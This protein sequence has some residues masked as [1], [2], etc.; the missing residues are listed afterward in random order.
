MNEEKVKT[1]KTEVTLRQQIAERQKEVDDLNC[2][3]QQQSED[4]EAKINELLTRLQEQT[5]LAVKLQ[6]EIDE[7]EW[8]EEG[9]EKNVELTQNCKEK[10]Q[11][12]TQQRSLTANNKEISTRS[13]SSIQMNQG[14]HLAGSLASISTY[15]T[16]SGTN[17]AMESFR[18]PD[19]QSYASDTAKSDSNNTMEDSLNKSCTDERLKLPL[20]SNLMTSDEANTAGDFSEMS[21]IK[22]LTVSLA[23]ISSYA[24]AAGVNESLWVPQSPDADKSHSIQ[25]EIMG[26]PPINARNFEEIPN[27]NM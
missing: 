17:E 9:E 23:T 5:T 20:C 24:T 3:Y 6:T 26:K 1:S 13:S 10:K 14:S 15:A 22:S 19:S 11:S 2:Y 21:H 16:L 8:Y 12:S 18:T 27:N 7:Y 4:Y 25:E